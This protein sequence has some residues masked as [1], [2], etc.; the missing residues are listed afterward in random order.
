VSFVAAPK[1]R[2]QCND[3]TADDLAAFP[4]WEFAL[5]EEGVEGQDETTVR[6]FVFTG[7]LDTSRGSFLVKADYTLAD[8]SRSLGFLTPPPPS[9]A[10]DLGHVQPCIV[11]PS[12]HVNFWYGAF[13]VTPEDVA[14]GYSR[15]GKTDSAQVFPIKFESA[16]PLKGESV[17][18][19]IP[20]F[21]GFEDWRAGS[22]RVAK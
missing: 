16:V 9:A 18:G 20:G 7:V 8:G 21:L 14:A 17:K 13:P 5:D 2:K 4:V 15:L 12:G 19:S 11:T 22:I 1:I 6:P 10:R 3:L